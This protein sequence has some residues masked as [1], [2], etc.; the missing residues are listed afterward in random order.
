VRKV[1]I[2]HPVCEERTVMKPCYRYV[3]E[4][5]MVKKCVNRGRWECRTECVGPSLLD[6][7]CSG[8]RRSRCGDPCAD[9]CHNQ[10]NHHCHNP[11]AR[12]R[13]RRGEGRESR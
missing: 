12:T 6:R 2:N 9:P 4:T 11:C 8:H 1:C 3:R 10:V 13:T 5:V 7:L